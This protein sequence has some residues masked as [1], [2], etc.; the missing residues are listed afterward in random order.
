M[1]T[2]E[3]LTEMLVGWEATEPTPDDM[4]QAS[5]LADEVSEAAFMEDTKTAREKVLLI[6]GLLWPASN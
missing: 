3:D 2:I 1:P 6:V 5:D 4:H